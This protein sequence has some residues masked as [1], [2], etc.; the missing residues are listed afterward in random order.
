MDN[1]A[2]FV[3]YD[4]D[5]QRLEDK[6]DILVEMLSKHDQKSTDNFHMIIMNDESSEKLDGIRKRLDKL[7]GSKG[8]KVK[9]KKVT[10]DD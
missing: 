6:L 9:P 5:I 8:I 4:M 7:S 1:E 3:K 2:R 10:Y